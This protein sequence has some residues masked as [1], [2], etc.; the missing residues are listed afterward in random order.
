MKKS[1]KKN[2]P[3][4][5][6][7]LCTF[8][9]SG[10]LGADQKGNSHQTHNKET[11]EGSTNEPKNESRQASDDPLRNTK[12]LVVSGHKSLYENG[13][14]PV[15]ST[16]LRFIPP[17][18][19]AEIFIQGRRFQFAKSSFQDS[20]KK[21][22]ESVIVLKEGH[23]LS[24]RLAKET[25]QESR[26]ISN[27]I[28]SAMILPGF[29]VMGRAQAQTLGIAG[30]TWTRGLTYYSTTKEES[31]RMSAVLYGSAE[32]LM[33]GNP[34]KIEKDRIQKQKK[35][36]EI[37]QKKERDKKILE[38]KIQ[39]ET[40][41]FVLG[42]TD[43]GVRTRDRTEELVENLDEA[44]YREVHQDWNEIRESVS[45]SMLEG[46]TDTWLGVMG[47]VQSQFSKIGAELES[48]ESGAGLSWAILKS[49]VFATKALFYDAVIQPIG[50]SAIYGIGYVSWNS[51]V[52]PV[53]LVTISGTSVA[54]VLV[55]VV[56]YGLDGTTA[57]VAPTG[58]LALAGILGGAK[59]IASQSMDVAQT[60]ITAT[61]TT[62]EVVAG[63]LGGLSLYG[64]GFVTE[65]SGKYLV[66]PVAFGTGA[67]QEAVSGIGTYIWDTTKGATMAG[68]GSLATVAT[69]T[70]GHAT[71]GAIY[72]SGTTVSAG[73][74]GSFGVYY[75]GKA[76]GVP[77]GVYVGSGVVMSY[78]MVAQLS[79]HT[80]LAAADMTYL[81]LSLEGGRWV[82][83]GVKHTGKSAAYILTGSVVDL[84][85]IR[86]QGG[87][88]YQIPV[89]DEEME[90]V[91]LSVD[92][93]GQPVKKSSGHQSGPKPRKK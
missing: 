6:F 22:A 51:V 54:V 64:T 37:Q 28:R 71:A 87:E 24:Y 43:L 18:N 70:A 3:F 19:E 2:F 52:Y 11:K 78:E 68:S 65:N 53:G 42:Y 10:A 17:A 67:T 55:E 41:R 81:V 38:K 79:A 23:D 63:K 93:K 29:Y 46:V 74:A 45:D 57:I 47:K 8:V 9:F 25:S 26:D 20:L 39:E 32:E 31:E 44:L 73:T 27:S 40:A 91:L 85:S 4:V 83:Y 48:V 16:S 80:V 35:A 50:E 5:A 60:G 72:V 30:K 61:A 12:K 86:A 21:A 59:V 75:V 82:L 33:F 66:A 14:F 62:G 1:S 58:R 88:V 36:L 77:M 56:D 7:L 76:L 84:D 92:K 90:K 13:A 15:G 34:E 69:L 89:S 49:F